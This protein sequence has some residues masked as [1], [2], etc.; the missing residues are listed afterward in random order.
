MSIEKDDKVFLGATMK[1]V[2]GPWSMPLPL[3]S[4]VLL[5]FWKGW[6]S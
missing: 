1:P 6:V 4:G 5:Q 3:E 2:K